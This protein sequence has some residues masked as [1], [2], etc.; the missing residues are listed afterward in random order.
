MKSEKTVRI[1]VDISMTVMLLFSYAYRITGEKAHEWIGI[2][3]LVLAIAHN[4]LNRKWYKSMFKGKYTLT[5]VLWSGTN[6]LLAIA[7][8]AVFVT[9]LLQSR[10]VLAFLNLP[11][12][13]AIQQ[14]HT[15]AAY[16]AIPLIG[17]HMGFHWGMFTKYIGNNY[18]I[19]TVMR[20]LSCMFVVFG[21]WSFIDRDMFAKLFQGFS[22][23]YW[24]PERPRILFFAQTLSVMG[25]YVFATYYVIKLKNWLK[26]RQ[27][28]IV[29]GG[30]Q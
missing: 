19:V 21:V 27:Q 25:I 20:I 23:D 15:S 29:D 7:F 26:N 18:S 1:S 6:V 22:F 14:I 11:G 16:W 4:I 5:R 12:S 9:G 2:A 24:Q 30:F 17:I 3:V 8:T 13:L 28:K 10:T